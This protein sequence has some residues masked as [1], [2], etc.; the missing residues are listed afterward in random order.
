MDSEGNYDW[1]KSDLP[2]RLTAKALKIIRG[3]PLRTPPREVIFLDRKTGGVF[4]FLSVLGAKL[5][6]R[7]LITSALQTK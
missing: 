7:P 4:V 5:N 3:F 6:A 2:K 1:K